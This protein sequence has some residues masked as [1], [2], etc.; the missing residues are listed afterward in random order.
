MAIRKPLRE[1]L[2]TAWNDVVSVD[3][4][5]QRINSERSL[6][7]AY[8]ARLNERLSPQFRMFIEPGFRLGKS[9]SI[10][11]PDLVICN[12]RSIIA[13]IELKYRPRAAPLFQKDVETLNT[14]ATHGG[15]LSLSNERFLG[16][17]VD[18]RKYEFAT[19]TLF[20]WGGFHRAPKNGSSEELFSKVKE[21]KAL[22]GRF[23]H[24]HAE[25]RKD[26]CAKVSHQLT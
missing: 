14:L 2:I 5:R 7:A 23:L 4:K 25:T 8:W 1:H 9:G 11:Y 24:L 22:A 26:C 6:Q 19:N 20:V 13:V 10:Y 12:S 3:Y 21:Y 17:V 18:N 16:E 15:S